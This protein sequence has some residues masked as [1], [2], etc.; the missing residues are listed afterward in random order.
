MKSMR[1]ALLALLA[2]SCS[3]SRESSLKLDPTPPLS[4]GPGW[5]VVKGAYV[6]LKETPSQAARDLSHLR[7]GEVI[8]VIGR[9]L[10][11]PGSE[12]DKG[13]WYR[14]KAEAGSGW[15]RESDLDVFAT[16]AQADRSASG[17]R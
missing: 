9:D 7:R 10:G 3:P 4:G 1:F 6:R 8:E 11:S 17:Y 16:K 5:A 13:L 2:L 15:A 12:E 14:L